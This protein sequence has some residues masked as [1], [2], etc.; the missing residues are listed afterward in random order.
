MFMS[1][2]TMNPVKVANANIRSVNGVCPGPY[3]VVPKACSDEVRDCLEAR[4]VKYR[5]TK[6]CK[7]STEDLLDLELPPKDMEPIIDGWL[8]LYGIRPEKGRIGDS[9]NPFA[10]LWLFRLHFV[11]TA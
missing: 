5:I 2:S 3:L 8:K 6:G 4:G 7:S 11:A 1:V 10:L 9:M